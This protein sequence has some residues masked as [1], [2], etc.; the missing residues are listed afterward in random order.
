MVR[1]ATRPPLL[2]FWRDASG[3]GPLTQLRVRL[4]C[5]S[6]TLRNP[7]PHW[8]RGQ[9]EG[10]SRADGPAVQQTR[11]SLCG[12]L[13]PGRLDPIRRRGR[14]VMAGAGFRP[15]H[16]RGDVADRNGDDAIR[17]PRRE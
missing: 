16:R 13:R 7:L 9:G 10:D 8:G 17:I 4:G 11:L 12:R 3:N 14:F 2:T 15:T 6:P 1:I 5:A